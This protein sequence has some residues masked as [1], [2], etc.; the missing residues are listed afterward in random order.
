MVK[1][2]HVL[3]L[4]TGNSARSILGEALL[5][6]MADGRYV[7]HSAGSR[8]AQMPNPYALEL[9]DKEGFDI[10]KLRSKSWDEFCQSDAH[11]VDFVITV[12]DSA[13][14]EPCPLFSTNVPIIHWGL[15]DPAGLADAAE[16][17][18]AF[19]QTYAA[20]TRRIQRMLALDEGAG[21]SINFVER[22][23]Q[24]GVER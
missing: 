2:R 5:N 20:L 11:P 10:T 23:Q 8:P 19:Q 6:R 17:R 22:L 15:P 4:C 7:A 21:T 3:F 16:S 9:L 13:S 1:A 14:R 12:C 18:R 24:C